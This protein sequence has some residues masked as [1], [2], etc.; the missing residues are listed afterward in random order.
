MKK[1]KTG[2]AR[3]GSAVFISLFALCVAGTAVANNYSQIVNST[4]GIETSVVTGEGEM[5]Y[6]SEYDNL[7]EMFQEKEQLLREIG[8]EGTVLL[9]N[10]GTLPLE[11]GASVTVVNEDDFVFCGTTG[12]SAMSGE[13]TIATRAGL[14]EALE[15]AGL[16]VSTDEDTMASADAVIVVIGRSAGEGSDLT[17]GSLELTSEEISQI[18]DAKAANDSVILLVSGDQPTE[19]GAYKS[20][21]SVGAIVKFGNAGYRGAYG[22]ADVIAGDVSPSGRLVDT[23]AVSAYSAPA[24]EN[25]GDLTF[26]NSSKIMA[27]QANKYI[28]YSEGI[29]TDYR[30]YETRYEDCVLSQGNAD[31]SAGSTTGSSWSYSSEVSWGFGYGLSY[32]SFEKTLAGDPVFDWEEKT[33]TVEVSVENTGSVSGK[34]VVEV[35]SQSPYTDYDGENGVEKASVELV[36]FEK[37]GTLAPGE[38]ETVTV[39]VPLQWV[40]SYDYQG[41]EGYI[42]DAGEYFLSVGNGAH[43]ALNNILAAKGYGTADGMDY[44]GDDSLAWAWEVD[45]LDTETFADSVYTGNEVTNA[46][47]DIDLN[48][49]IDGAVTYLSR[50]DWKGTYPEELALEAST[51]M[52]SFLNDTKRYENGEWNDTKSRAEVQDVTYADYSTES[53]VNSAITGGEI[54]TESVVSMRGK[55]YDDEGWEEILDN[56]S[57]YEMSRMV[58]EGRYSINACPT[59]SFAECYGTDSPIGFWAAYA[60]MSVDSETGDTVAVTSSDTITDAISGEEISLSGLYGD[61][62][63]SEP[64]LAATFNKELAARQGA[65]FGED[66]L[67]TGQTFLWGL[68][69]NLHRTGY[70]GRI[71]EYY[72]SDPV[73]SAL[74]G[75]EVSKACKE[76]GVVLVGKHLVLNEQDQ[77][78]IGVSTFCNEQALRELY[79]RPFEGVATYGEGQGFMTAY[80]RIGMQ[81]CTAEYDLCTVV[82]R[83][84]WG[85]QAYLISDLNSPTAGLYDGNAGIAAGLSTFLNNG[86]YNA[87]SG[88]YVNCTL[89]TENIKSDETLLYAAREACHRMLFQFIHSNGANGLSA[90]SQ[91]LYVT[92]WWQPTLIVI[93]VVLGVLAVGCSGIY[94]VLANGMTFRGK[95]KKKGEGSK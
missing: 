53:E 51:D 63:S 90:D 11:G 87:S 3:L 34:E 64:V 78:R 4:L 36:G 10:D 94:L 85:S 93:D 47:E 57:I 81:S 59:V 28:N 44:A 75:A 40:A 66:G 72:S 42:L 9:K 13:Q 32:T 95:D 27:S 2:L 69:L 18:S 5:Y 60:Y 80:N 38:S 39:T 33:A 7:E 50:S 79:L 25:W 46:F 43:D 71:S 41:A 91:V 83:G 54:E 17:E 19:V 56:L 1:P 22:L 37:T 30:Y 76:H 49:W 6:T 20:D 84:E 86:T 62:Y 92:P 74:I 67:Y 24:M 15:N 52:I 73:H 35:Y 89:S 29:Y 58:A 70:G 14:A 61:V 55:D 88:A 8:Q 77:N 16:S 82:M 45:S 21:S 12:G 31:S 48:Y 23:M 68:G 26:S 65:M